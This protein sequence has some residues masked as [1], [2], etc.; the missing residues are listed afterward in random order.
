VTLVAAAFGAF[1][2]SGLAFLL[3]ERR[4]RRL[5]TDRR[6]SRLLEAQLALG[7]QLEK[8]LNIQHG[9]LDPHR[10]EPDRHM[11]LEPLHMSMTDLR[12]DFSA[13]VFIAEVDGL[14]I[15]QTVYLAEQAYITATTAL[16]ES[17]SKIDKRPSDGAITS[18]PVDLEAS[19]AIAVFDSAAAADLKEFIDD[20]YRSVDEAIDSVREAIKELTS[21]TRRLYPKRKAHHFDPLPRA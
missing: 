2:G 3:E 18:G 21:A 9:Y 13:L 15:L 7:M 8:L 1:F 5:E 20:L 6:Y 17:N 12:V 14:G 4:R 11:R 16:A 10:T 19:A